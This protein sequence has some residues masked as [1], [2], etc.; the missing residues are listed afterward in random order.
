MLFLVSEQL[1]LG[2]FDSGLRLVEFDLLHLAFVRDLLELVEAFFVRKLDLHNPLEDKIELV[3][4]LAV[5]KDLTFLFELHELHFKQD[6]SD[7]GLRQAALTEKR[8]LRDVLS[9]C[10]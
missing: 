10:V 4:R 2:V 6:V 8:D 3:A 1:S 9:K 7:H 5:S